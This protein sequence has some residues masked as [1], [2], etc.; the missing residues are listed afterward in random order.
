M[1]GALMAS[2]NPR[3]NDVRGQCGQAMVEFIVSALFFLV[4][5]FLAI[6]ALGKFIDV[7]HTAEM[8]G[9]YAAWE[10]TV[11]YE[12]N[13]S[14][15][16]GINQPNHKSAAAINNE[17]GARLLNDRSTNATVIRDSDKTAAAFING[18]DP[19]WR[20]A[21]GKV[22]LDTYSQLSSTVGS[23]TP[24]KDVAG[25]ALTALGKISVKGVIGFVPPVPSDNLAVAVV[26]LADVGKKSEV[27]QR[28]WKEAPAWAGLEFKAT[29]A[30]LSNTWG[31]NSSTGTRAMVKPT[32]PTAGALGLIV[33]AAQVGILPW[34]WTVPPRIEVGKIEVDV[35]PDDRLK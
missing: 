29:G 11:W 20:D 14:T 13:G 2:M 12:D 18:I 19:M 16:D 24:T 22:Y 30:I 25:A 7:Q 6:A 10:R 1:A 23:E 9:R 3:K 33:T 8:A 32:V 28:L 34:D 27:Y 4:P 31:A 15:F 26:T 5:L 35:L 21:N 17:I